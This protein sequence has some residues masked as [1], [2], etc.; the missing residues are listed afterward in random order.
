MQQRLAGD[1]DPYLRKRVPR[2][3]IGECWAG[4]ARRGALASELKAFR[5]RIGTLPPV[6]RK[7][8]RERSAG[9]ERTHG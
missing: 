4:L 6:R 5:E 9:L 7:R 1:R 2:E 8:A 3:R